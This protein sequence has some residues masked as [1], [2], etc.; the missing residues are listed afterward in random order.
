MAPRKKTVEDVLKDV[1]I[2]EL[3]SEELRVVVARLSA[4]S[5]RKGKT[6]DPYAA[7]RF[8]TSRDSMVQRLAAVKLYEMKDLQKMSFRDMADAFGVSYERV[9][10]LYYKFHPKAHADAEEESD[11]AQEKSA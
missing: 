1:E 3:S 5:T 8:G 9:R 4:L 6:S 11:H 10:Q 7:Q 2:E